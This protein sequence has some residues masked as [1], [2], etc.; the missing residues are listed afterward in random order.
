MFLEASSN[1]WRRGTPSVTFLSETPAKWKVF[2]VIC[3]VGSPIDWAATEPIASPAGAR[4]W[5]NFVL[6][7]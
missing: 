7:Y 4:D 5:L 2:R 6:I 3:V 1:Y